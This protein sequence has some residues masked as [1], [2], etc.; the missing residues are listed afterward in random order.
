MRSQKYDGFVITGSSQ[1]AHSDDLWVRELIHL[2]EETQLHEEEGAWH[3]FYGHQILCRA[4]GGKTGRGKGVAT[5]GGGGGGMVGE[6]PGGDVQAWQAEA[7]KLKLE[8]R[9]PNQ[10]AWKK[11]CK[12]FLKG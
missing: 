4:L 8:A 3:L 6:N 12:G 7:A 11:L 2:L 1:D 9:E 10:E 5:D